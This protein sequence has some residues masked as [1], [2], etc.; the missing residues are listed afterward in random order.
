MASENPTGA[1]TEAAR[2]AALYS[3]LRRIYRV[4]GFLAAQQVRL[5]DVVSIDTPRHGLAGGVL[6]RVVA[7]RENITGGSVELEVFV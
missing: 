2:R 5:G 1:A 7:M 4:R 3:V 6:A